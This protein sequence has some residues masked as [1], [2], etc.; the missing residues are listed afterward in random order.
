VTHITLPD[1]DGLKL[2]T[3]LADRT[4]LPIIV[5]AGFS[6]V[7]M[8]V[9]AMKAGAFEFLTKS[10][11]DRVLRIVIGNALDTSRFVPARWAEG[12]KAQA[13]QIARSPGDG[14]HGAR[15]GEDLEQASRCGARY[16]RGHGQGT[17]RKGDAQDGR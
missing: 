14:G 6:D 12:Q 16:L 7:L 10:V 17:R 3:P 15:G 8:A 2:Q 9:R 11:V 5:I 13:L 4:E 1:L